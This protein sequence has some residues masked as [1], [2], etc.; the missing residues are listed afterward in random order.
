M[1][2]QALRYQGMALCLATDGKFSLLLDVKVPELMA[3]GNR[4]ALAAALHDCAPETKPPLSAVMR[5]S[6]LEALVYFLDRRLDL[7]LAL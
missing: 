7:K 5:P 4:Q 1:G 2:Q 3:L 6:D